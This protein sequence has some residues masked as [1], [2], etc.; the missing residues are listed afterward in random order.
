MGVDTLRGASWGSRGMIGFSPAGAGVIE[1]LPDAGGAP[2]PV[3]RMEHGDTSHRWPEFLPGGES[4]LFATSTTT[5]GWNN[6]QIVAQSLSANERHNLVQGAT[7]P[8]YASPGYL[9]YVRAGNLLAA[10]FDAKRLQITG[11]AV[12]V[13][14]GVRQSLAS[15]SAQYVV[16]R[17]GTLA[18]VPGGVEN[19]QNKLVWVSRKGT[20]QLLDAPARSYSVPRISPDGGRV[21]LDPD[22][23]I[24]LYDIARKILTRLTF[25]GDLN[26]RPL[27]TPDG[28]H[29]IFSS[30]TGGQQSIFWQLADGSGGREQLISGEQ[31]R[32]PSSISPDGRYLS[33]YDIDPNTQLDIWIL[34]LR[35]RKARVFLQ[36]RFNESAS[37]F[38]PD[39]RWLAYVSDESGRAEIYV[40]SF[41]GPGG[42]WQISTEGGT[43]PVWNRNGRELLYRDGE[44]IM[45]VEVSVQ[46]AFA[47]GV[48]KQVFAGSYAD[49]VIVPT[50]DMT[51]DGQRF[52]VLKADEQQAANNQIVIVQNWFEELKRLVPAGTK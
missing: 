11:P 41:P 36:T 27:W 21:A 13:V 32:V 4:I 31:L 16:S 40:Q 7:Q 38:S 14:E 29:V 42:K 45:S 52:L 3:T 2:Q 26:I 25:D 28:K 46:P 50:Y 24:W 6:A 34:D 18:Y 47:A 8:R 44:R 22:G 39:G 33:Y 9:L 51:P 19:A 1:T 15:G 17:T 49:P 30:A 5:M 37:A 12:T 35:D 43:E 10:P 23:Q 20:E 48:P